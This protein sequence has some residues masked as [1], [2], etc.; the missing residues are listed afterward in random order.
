MRPIALNDIFDEH[1]NRDKPQK[2]V[3]I[4]KVAKDKKNPSAKP[5]HKSSKSKSVPKIRK[6]ETQMDDK[7]AS[8]RRERR[9]DTDNEDKEASARRDKRLN[10]KYGNGTSDPSAI[11]ATKKHDPKK[12]RVQRTDEVEL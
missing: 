2:V 10:D 3:E 11:P 12:A 4:L 5:V 8:A 6:D 1:K 9:D 7:A